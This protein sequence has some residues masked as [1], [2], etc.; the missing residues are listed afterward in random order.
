MNASDPTGKGARTYMP[1]R[2]RLLDLVV[3][4]PAVVVSAPLVLL[5]AI[6]SAISFKA[7]PLFVQPR[8]GL[9]GREFWFVKIRSLP[10][11]A[12]PAADKYELE[13][14]ETSAWGQFLRRWHLDELPQ[15]WLVMTGRMTLVGPRPEMPH[16]SAKFDPAFARERVSVVPGCTGL[17]QMSTAVGGLIRE[18]PE[19]DLHYVHHWTLRLDVW[20][21]MKTA[22]G[23]FGGSSVK[24]VGQIPAWT[25]A[26][27]AEPAEALA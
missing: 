3:A 26:D 18:A 6:G 8:V 9:N 25:G 19:F 12:P 17:W 5:L 21:L 2:K 15:V 22:G 20:L 23:F 16:L 27:V 1:I 14:V 4:V 13:F 10:T 24:D 7:W 11:S